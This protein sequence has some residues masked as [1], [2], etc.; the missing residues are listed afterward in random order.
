MSSAM[1]QRQS[2]LPAV[3]EDEEHAA[4][5]SSSTIPTPPSSKRGKKKKR[6]SKGRHQRW[7]MLSAALLLIILL[8][9]FLQWNKSSNDSMI[10]LRRSLF[11][12]ETADSST[13]Q[14][15]KHHQLLS[16]EKLDKSLGI[17]SSSL[18]L[19]VFF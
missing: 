5:V 8:F 17:M 13:T 9:I 7:M 6:R 1:R 10:P 11:Q 14:C 12:P 3:A 18:L 16:R 19:F 15:Q 2:S 4:A